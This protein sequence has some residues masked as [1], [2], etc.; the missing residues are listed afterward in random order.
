MLYVGL[1]E[2]H[3]ESATMFADV[4]G[5]QVISQLRGSSSVAQTVVTNK[6]GVLLLLFLDGLLVL[7]NR[8]C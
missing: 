4:V 6:S 2:D 3:R 1:T 5:A 7:L 8:F